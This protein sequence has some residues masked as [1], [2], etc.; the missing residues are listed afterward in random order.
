MS[1]L[2]AYLGSDVDRLVSPQGKVHV[3][4]PWYATKVLLRERA[5]DATLLKVCYAV[6]QQYSTGGRAFVRRVYTL[7]PVKHW[8]TREAKT[9]RQSREA[10]A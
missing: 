9:M 10:L 8:K 3:A 6:P 7:C 1:F 5:V 4:D 2:L